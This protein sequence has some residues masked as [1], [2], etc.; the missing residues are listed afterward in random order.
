MVQAVREAGTG[1]TEGEAEVN[2]RDQLI[3]AL[4]DKYPLSTRFV[5]V[6]A[7][8]HDLANQIRDASA[9]ADGDALKAIHYAADEIDPAKEIADA[10]PYVWGSHG[11]DHPSGHAGDHWC[12]HRPHDFDEPG[13]VRP[14]GHAD[15]W[16]YKTQEKETLA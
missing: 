1:D 16:H 15:V 9:G 10:C 3:V 13:E 2:A 11:C 8:A 5:M 6:D 12:D 14:R 7:F 4:G